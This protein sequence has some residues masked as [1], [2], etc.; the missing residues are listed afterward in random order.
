MKLLLN[1]SVLLIILSYNLFA[2][3]KYIITV[4]CNGSGDFKTINEAVESL[5]LFNYQRVILKIKNGVY[6]EKFK[7]D[8]DYISLIGEDREKTII[9]YNQ[10]RSDWESNKDSIGPA[11]ININGDDIII[12]NLTVEN[13]QPEIGPHAFAIYGKGTRTIILNCN[14]ISKGAD[15]VS[16]WD[17][18]TGMYYHADCYFEGAVDFVCPRG[19]CFIKNSKFYEV[20]KTAA[21]WHAGGYNKK[22]KF[23][24]KDSYFDGIKD[25]D[26]GRH[27]Y[28]AQFY[29]LNCT[30]SENMSDK[31]IFR[32]TY[33]DTT[34]NQPFNWGERYYFY[35]CSREGGNYDWIENNLNKAEGKPSADK[36]TAEWT[37]DFMWNPES[38]EGPAIINYEISG[39]IIKLFFD[40]TVTVVDNPVLTTSSKKELKYSAGAGSNT[41]LF[42][43]DNEIVKNDLTEMRILSGKLIGT[44]A[45]VAERIVNFKI[46][47]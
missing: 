30:F 9:K 18:K 31:K 32:V 8:Q 17:Y 15:T 1:L 10:L 36:I 45:S 12:Q 37:F 47:L 2:Q 33:E 29:L 38:E 23:V 44:R 11:V 13:T 34:R 5:P 4:D 39:N 22:Q 41:L 21:L 43:S 20:K 25:F 27:H 3:K 14:L 6:E 28:E 26:L 35:N 42:N 46:K 40:E 24:I 19:W 7:I 16:L